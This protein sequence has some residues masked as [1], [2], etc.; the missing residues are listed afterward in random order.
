MWYNVV[1]SLEVLMDVGRRAIHPMR[2][3]AAGNTG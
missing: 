2:R 1:N 3:M